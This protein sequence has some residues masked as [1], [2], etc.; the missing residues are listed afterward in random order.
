MKIIAI[1][2]PSG[3]GKS[4][5][6]RAVASRL[7]YLYLDT[8]A[9]YRAVGLYILRSGIPTKDEDLV[10]EALPN[11]DLKIALDE[12]G[13]KIWLNDEDVTGKI[14]TNE[15]SMAASDVSSLPAV[16]AFLL[17]LQRDTAKRQS[18]V[19]DGRDIGT[20]VFPDADVK[21]FLTAKEQVRAKRRYDELKEKGEDISFQQ[22]LDDLHERD[23]NDSHRKVAPLKKAKDA[24][25]VD[26]SNWT[27]E[28]TVDYIQRRI[29][30]HTDPFDTQSSWFY[31]FGY[32]V[33]KFILKIFF[34]VEIRG[35]ENL[36]PVG[37]GFVL[38]CNHLSFLDPVVMGIGVGKDRKLVFMAK[39]QLFKNPIFGAIIRKL[40]AF[41][42]SRGKKD[43]T[44]L[45]VAERRVREGRI[46]ALFP[47]GT[48]SLTG[49]LLKPKSGIAVIALKTNADVLPAAI[50]YSGKHPFAKIILSFGPVIPAQQLKSSEDLTAHQQTREAT[51]YIW[52]RV[53]KLYE[54]EC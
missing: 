22:V 23:F 2:G 25:E 40:G 8:G 7:G 47:E 24:A 15:V 39:E 1:D 21:I 34:R 19:L 12:S 33:C 48:R 50:H 35:R 3:A 27:I 4:T 5:V 53:T 38:C 28:E 16:R 44:A 45:I 18:V 9:L 10:K 20:V 51:R 6:A 54:E 11:I 31:T 29:E 52:E 42:V 32:A 37:S 26:S 14:R 49:K 36:P 17:N 43:K 46:L 30:K 41:P 13:Q